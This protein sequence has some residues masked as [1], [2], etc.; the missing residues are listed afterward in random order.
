MQH[1][2]R[3]QFDAI[4]EPSSKQYDDTAASVPFSQPEPQLAYATDGRSNDRSPIPSQILSECNTADSHS[5]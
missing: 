2:A 5:E 4:P 1:A 3:R